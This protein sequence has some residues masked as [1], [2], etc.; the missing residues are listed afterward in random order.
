MS[1]PNDTTRDDLAGLVVEIE[2]RL[3]TPDAIGAPS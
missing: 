1:D 3:L 2:S